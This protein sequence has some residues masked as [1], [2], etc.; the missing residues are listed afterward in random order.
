MRHLRNL[1]AVA[2]LALALAFAGP[3]LAQQAAGNQTVEN[4]QGAATTP[5]QRTI[6]G[7]DLMTAEERSGFRRQMQQATP[8][9]RQQLWG[10]KRAE[11]QQRAAQRGLVLAEPAALSGG[12]AG[13]RGEDRRGG[14]DGGRGEGGRSM[15]SWMMGG[16]PRAP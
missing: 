10:Q 16:A 4:S 3:A 12:N 8:E 6:R 5:A 11:L 7:R 9:Q 13:G 1:T 15:M 2:T 14:R